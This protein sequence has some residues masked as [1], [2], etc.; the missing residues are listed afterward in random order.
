MI[1]FTLLMFLLVSIPPATIVLHGIN[2]WHMARYGTQANEFEWVF[3]M[4][5]MLALWPVFI[6]IVI[7]KK[8]K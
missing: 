6:W 7:N 4:V 5:I 2:K 1:S 8:K 3:W